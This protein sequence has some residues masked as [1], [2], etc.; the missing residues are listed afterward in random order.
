MPF[1]FHQ[2][3]THSNQI[4]LWRQNSK[5]EST[6]SPSACSSR[7]YYTQA[8]L[9]L[10]SFL[11]HLFIKC[12]PNLDK[13]W[14]MQENVKLRQWRAYRPSNISSASLLRA[15]LTALWFSFCH[16]LSFPTTEVHA[17]PQI[18]T[19]TIPS[20]HIINKSETKNNILRQVQKTIYAYTLMQC[21]EDR[22]A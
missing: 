11:Y 3:S 12:P 14:T 2:R 20:Q 13:T 4:H 9:P 10:H 21:W 7:C 22:E 6:F 15:L 1:H 17:R 8:C 18:H 5:T 16:L 19:N